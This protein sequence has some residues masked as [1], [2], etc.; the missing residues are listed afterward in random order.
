M[1][2]YGPLDGKAWQ[3]DGNSGIISTIFDWNFTS[4]CS[5]YHDGRASTSRGLILMAHTNHDRTIS[6]SARNIISITSIPNK[7]NFARVI[8]GDMSTT[9]DSSR[10]RRQQDCAELPGMAPDHPAEGTSDNN[11]LS[12]HCMQTKGR[13]YIVM[14][15][16]EVRVIQ[17]R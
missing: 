16:Y 14:H 11:I 2:I 8:R 13:P 15:Y 3:K 17:C 6:S 5:S 10:P 1:L 9:A 4:G 7:Y 12:H